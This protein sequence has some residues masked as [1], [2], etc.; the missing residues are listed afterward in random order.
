M[1]NWSLL[2]PRNIFAIALMGIAAAVVFSFLLKRV[3]LD[4]AAP[5][6]G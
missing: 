2:T 5:V 1:L 6:Q 3:G 4:D